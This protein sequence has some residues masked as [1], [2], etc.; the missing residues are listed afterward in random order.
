VGPRAD[1]EAVACRKLPCPYLE[2][3]P[4]L[5]AHNLVTINYDQIRLQFVVD[6]VTVRNYI[7]KMHAVF[8]LII[9]FFYI[10]EF[11]LLS[12]WKKQNTADVTAA[13]CSDVATRVDDVILSGSREQS[14]REILEMMRFSANREDCT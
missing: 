11:W 3:N 6:K 14:R 12:A 7:I 13:R 10:W 1:L 9:C 4:T 5:P 2:S 8:R